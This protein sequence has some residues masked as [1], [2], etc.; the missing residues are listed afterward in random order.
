MT[1]YP[2]PD[3]LL[4][5]LC[6]EAREATQFALSAVHMV[7]HTEADASVTNWLNSGATQADQLLRSLDGMLDLLS[8]AA[9]A[10]AALE[11]FDLAASV[12]S[13]VE[14]LNLAAGA[15]GT[16]LIVGS[17]QPLHIAQDRQAMEQVVTRVL[18][19][20]AKL[21]PCAKI[22]V[23]LSAGD[24]EARLSLT[25]SHPDLAARWLNSLNATPNHI[26]MHMGVEVPVAIAAMVAGKHLR[27]LQGRAEIVPSG[28][29][30][31]VLM[32]H[33]PAGAQ[34]TDA[35]THPD[36][37]SILVVEDCD[38]SF[39]LTGA[40]LPNEN[41]FRAS[42][43]FEALEQMQ[44]RRFDVVLMDVHMPG[45]DG[46][47]AIRHIRE[48]ETQTGSPRTPIIILSSD[49]IETQRN[50]AAQS[51]CSGFLHKP[52]REGDLS[53]FLEQLKRARSLAA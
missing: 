41:I 38:D 35:G 4:E 47:T 5:H 24:G 15:T 20:A 10:S 34:R 53:P 26:E 32:F 9:P 12:A 22:H 16:G 23:S 40:A 51:G 46:Y 19:A 21:A 37:L 33:L 18:D 52:I 45:M 2:V 43:G 11:E 42:D 30:L 31:S 25:A 50:S 39:I 44:K 1:T 8:S 17:M 27:A 7:P 13:I 14:G 29:S 49:D 36:A 6:K 48:W 28:P 3:V